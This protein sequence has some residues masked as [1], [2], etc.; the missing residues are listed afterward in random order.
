MNNFRK[1]LA[2]LI[3]CHSKENVSDTPDFILAEY[4]V[5]CLQAFDKATR[6]R[7]TW[8]RRDVVPTPTTCDHVYGNT[9]DGITCLKCGKVQ[10][11]E[12]VIATRNRE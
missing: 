1:E 10:P 11:Q 4:L 7:D 5:D 8:Y 2:S 9:T 12:V 3:N 6:L